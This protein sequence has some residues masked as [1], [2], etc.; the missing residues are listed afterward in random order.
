MRQLASDVVIQGAREAITKYRQR[1]QQ[2]SRLRPLAAKIDDSLFGSSS[3]FRLN[4]SIG[5]SLF[6]C[7]R[8][9]R[10]SG[11]GSTIVT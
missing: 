1:V 10:F 11:S 7:S 8:G 3:V 9:K 4:R 6:G 2:K 5:R